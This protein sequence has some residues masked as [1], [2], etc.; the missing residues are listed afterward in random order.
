MELMTDLCWAQ[1]TITFDPSLGSFTLL[2][3]VSHYVNELVS[4]VKV[5][6][7]FRLEW[8][9]LVFRVWTH[10]VDCTTSY[11]LAGPACLRCLCCVCVCLYVCVYVFLHL[12][13][14]LLHNILMT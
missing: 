6:R 3:L 4:L 12:S 8:I 14:T 2:E 13:Q 11:L 9:V 7:L 5:F 10:Q 1:G